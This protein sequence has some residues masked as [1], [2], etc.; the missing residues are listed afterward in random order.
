[1]YIYIYICIYTSNIY[2]FVYWCSTV[3]DIPQISRGYRY[4]ILSNMIPTYKG[5]CGTAGKKGTVTSSNWLCTASR[6][7]VQQIACVANQIGMKHNGNNTLYATLKGWWYDTTIYCIYTAY[8][9]HIYCI[10]TAYVLHIYYTAYML[11]IKDHQGPNPAPNFKPH[12]TQSPHQ[13]FC[14]RTAGR[15]HSASNSSGS[16]QGPQPPHPHPSLPLCMLQTVPPEGQLPHS[17]S[18]RSSNQVDSTC[19][20]TPQIPPRAG[21][22][23]RSD[24]SGHNIA[25]W[26]SDLGS[27]AESGHL[28]QSPNQL[29]QSPWSPA[30]A[31]A[32]G[33]AGAAAERGAPN[34]GRRSSRLREKLPAGPT[35]PS[36]TGK[37][38]SAIASPRITKVLENEAKY[39]HETLLHL[40]PSV[41]S[42]L[43]WGHSLKHS[44]GNNVKVAPTGLFEQLHSLNFGHLW[45]AYLATL[46]EVIRML[47][48]CQ[49]QCHVFY[50]ICREGLRMSEV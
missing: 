27:F 23:D 16:C 31:G 10:Y 37:K 36:S 25:H 24:S 47:L 6:F 39:L 20:H 34:R 13:W 28:P 2:I 22:T 38:H 44:L 11:H 49:S 3:I 29:L 43:R 40:S 18:E 12:L 33:A 4:G 17:V 48:S 15:H 5:N 1:M 46:R 32:A 19:S 14:H 35:A 7:I 21:A 8:I 26:K 45:P 41:C 42:T 9:L 30:G 50:C